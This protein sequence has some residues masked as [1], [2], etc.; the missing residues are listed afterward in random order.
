VTFESE[1]G[2]E[3]VLADGNAFGVGAYSNG[4]WRPSGCVLFA[5]PDVAAA[6]ARVTALGGKLEGEIR[7]FPACQAQWCEESRRQLIRLAPPY[8]LA[9]GSVTRVECGVER[10]AGLV[11]LVWGAGVLVC[12]GG[13]RSAFWGRLR[14]TQFGRGVV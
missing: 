3:F 2:A 5:V 13:S 10:I 8:R 9:P 12:L 4:E 6:A 14:W 11:E 7:N 1:H